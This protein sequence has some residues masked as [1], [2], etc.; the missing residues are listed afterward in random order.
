MKAF[1]MKHKVVIL[2]MLAA[3]ALAIS[4]M[5]KGGEAS[6]KVLVFSGLIAAASWIARNLRGQFATITGLIGNSLAAYLTMQETGSVSYAQLVLQLI[7]SVLAALSAPAK[8]SGYE[9]TEVIKDA[10]KE[11]EAIQPT[12]IVPNPTNQP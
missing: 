9:K 7:I 5:V 3:V 1:L 2:G 4:E 12:H 10:K 8:S 11:G 6:V